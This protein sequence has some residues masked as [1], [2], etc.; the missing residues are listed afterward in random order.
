MD[1]EI[2]SNTP[3]T[4]YEAVASNSNCPTDKNR[5][6]MVSELAGPATISV[7][8]SILRTTKRW[9]KKANYSLDSSPEP[10]LDDMKTI[11]YDL[12]R[13]PTICSPLIEKTEEK[14]MINDKRAN[15]NYSK[16]K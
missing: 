7:L 6:C 14:V 1:D 9:Q 13:M 12:L 5:E 3:C 4:F 16:N 10:I 11:A 15:K 2:S 8:P